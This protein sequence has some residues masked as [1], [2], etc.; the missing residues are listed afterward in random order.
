MDDSH[1]DS[2]SPEVRLLSRIQHSAANFEASF[3]PASRPSTIALTPWYRSRKYLLHGWTDPSIWAFS[4][5]HFPSLKP[6]LQSDTANHT[7]QIVELL[8]TSMLTYT[9]AQISATISSY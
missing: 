8:A 7:V 3:A 6:N 1:R 2:A 9:S 4:S 5:K